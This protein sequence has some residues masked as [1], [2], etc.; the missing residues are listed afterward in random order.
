MADMHKSFEYFCNVIRLSKSKK[1]NL[2]SSRDANRKRIEKY[3]REELKKSIPDFYQ[4]GSFSFKTTTNPIDSEY[5]VDDGVY[6][7]NLEENFI[8]ELKPT[9]VHKWIID[10]ENNATKA[11]VIDKPNCVRIVYANDYHIDMPIYA[12]KDDKYYLANCKDNTWIENDPKGFNDWFY[13]RFDLY[14]EQMRRNILYLKGWVD[15]NS[16]TKIRGILITILVCENQINI[17]IRDDESL[18]KTVSSIVSDLKN[19]RRLIMPVQPY[20]NL[21]GKMSETDIDNIIQKFESFETTAK[22]A[23]DE[24]D[25]EKSTDLWIEL[26]GDRFTF[27]KPDETK[28]ILDP[29]F[30]NQPI[31]PWGNDSRTF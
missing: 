29:I 24:S 22:K 14:G 27:K 10:A 11:S 13:R 6:L 20:D 12:K 26:F 1:E 15:Y 16:Y 17:N 2:V 31:K 9:T 21:L 23:L 19:N 7:N 8:E 3:F 4:Q 5:D 18:Q 30:I 25:E 28:N